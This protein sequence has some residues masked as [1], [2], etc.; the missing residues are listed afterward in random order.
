MSYLSIT[1]VEAKL[2][3]CFRLTTRQREPVEAT[4]FDYLGK[5]NM[6]DKDM[7]LHP[8]VQ[9]MSEQVL[10]TLH[11]GVNLSTDQEEEEQ[12]DQEDEE[13]MYEQALQK[14]KQR[15][16]QQSLSKKQQ[17]Y[18]KFF[19]NYEQESHPQHVYSMTPQ[20]PSSMLN[21]A[22]AGHPSQHGRGMSHIP[23]RQPTPS[24]SRSSSQNSNPPPPGRAPA[25]A[26]PPTASRAPAAAAP[27]PAAGNAPGAD[28]SVTTDPEQRKLAIH[29]IQ[30]LHKQASK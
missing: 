9:K 23:S 8:S 4:P 16:K 28:S 20:Q 14:H 13:S 30:D 15:Q 18:Q 3:L 11:F 27:A 12:G 19:P 26:R 21:R 5:W 24:Y 6:I 7:M 10:Y 1:N 29:H 2:Y 22:A 25:A 17:S